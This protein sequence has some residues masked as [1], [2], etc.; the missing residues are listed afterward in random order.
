[1]SKDYYKTLGVDKSASADEIKKAFRKMAHKYHP[2]KKDG[3]EVKFKEANEAYQ[4]LSDEK[5]RRQ[6]DQFG[7][8]G[9]NPFGNQGGGQGFGGFDFSGFQQG[10]GGF[11]FGDIDL[12]DLFGGGFG[13]RS[14]RRKRRRGSDM[15]MRIEIDF[16]DAVFGVKKKVTLDHTKTCSDCDG[17]GAEEG[18]S[19]DTCPE[20]NGQGKIQTQMM[21]IFATVTEC[22]TCEGSGKVP[23]EKCKKC[24]GAGV[25]REKEEIEFSIPAGIKNGDTLRISGRGGAVK[26][27]PSGDLFIQVLVK[28]HKSFRRNGL[29]LILDYE[30]PISDAVLGAKHTLTMLDDSK[31]D[32]KIP[33]GT[34]HGTTLRV[35]GKGIVTDR[36]KGNLLINIKIRIPK[37]LSK[38]AKEAIEV[39]QSE[40]Y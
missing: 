29:D 25:T 23:K 4:V 11:D 27:G 32:V 19:M 10:A 15:Q 20:C 21:G 36:S 6:Y 17:S 26:N 39:L 1:M 33:S 22:P 2:D 38:K 18:S 34:S 14:S 16:V 28:T 35:S 31:I 24:K 8:A 37:K 13:G 7:S 5:K 3:D 9:P 30:I 12:G 40:G